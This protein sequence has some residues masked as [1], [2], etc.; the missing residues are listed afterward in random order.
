L[1]AGIF[2]LHR[3]TLIRN[4]PLLAAVTEFLLELDVDALIPL[5]PAMRRTLGDLSSA[6]RRYLGETLGGVLGVESGA[7]V[8]L[9]LS[10]LERALL[11]EADAAV[12]AT[13]ADWMDRY[14][15]S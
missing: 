1:V 11:V 14:G 5:L 15:I 7:P 6:E 10:D 13:L 4:R 9:S 2:S 12:A 3:S 8:S